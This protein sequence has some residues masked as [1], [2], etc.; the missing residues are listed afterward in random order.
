VTKD[1]SFLAAYSWSKAI[2]YSEALGPAAAWVGTRPQDYFNRSLEKS[3][4]GFNQ[5]Q[6]LKLT[7]VWETPFGKGRHFDLH[8]ANLIAGGWQI[9]AIQNYATGFPIAVSQSGINV[10]AGFAGGIRPDVTGKPSAL[11]GIPSHVDTTVP[12]RYLD[13]AAFAHSPTTSN[14]TPLRVGTAPRFLPDVRGPAQYAETIRVSKRFYLWSEKAFFLI[15]ATWS[16]PLKRLRPYIVDTN[17]SNSAFGKVLQSGGGRT[18]QLEG[19]VEF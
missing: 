19:R 9:A 18:L 6:N 7:W 4:A 17:I 5:P 1:L 11:G 13:P 2:G 12:S 3:I 16:N 8:W 14:G 15:G 10:P